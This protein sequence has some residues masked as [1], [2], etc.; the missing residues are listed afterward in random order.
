ML[1]ARQ[2]PCR[3]LLLFD[4]LLMRSIHDS[5]E[6]HHE[7]AL[8]LAGGIDKAF[9][10]DYFTRIISPYR[11]SHKRSAHGVAFH[12]PQSA[13]F[14]REDVFPLVVLIYNATCIMHRCHIHRVGFALDVDLHHTVAFAKLL[15]VDTNILHSRWLVVGYPQEV[16]ATL[17]RLHIGRNRNVET[18]HSLHFCLHLRVV[19]VLQGLDVGF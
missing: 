8:L 2:M 17:A 7:V 16:L 5:F 10:G 1:F 3:L 12:F 9:Y 19:F 4:L 15:F 6:L 18:E 13:P 11:T 14:L